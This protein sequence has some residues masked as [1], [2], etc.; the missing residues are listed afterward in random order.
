MTQQ[1]SHAEQV[2]KLNEMI[3]DIN[4]AMLTTEE[5]DG[6]LRSRPMGTQQVDFDGDLWFFTRID[7]AKVD[8]VRRERHVNVSYADDDSQRYVS[9]SGTA[10]V[11]RDQK[12]INELWNPMAKIWFPDG[13]EDPSLALLKV[14]VTQAEYWDAASNRMVQLAKLAKGLITGDGAEELG[15][16]QK[17][18]L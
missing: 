2:E 5:A 18:A 8:E 6:T 13:K 17:L 4:I 14:H 9:V 11:M 15:D 3:R 16:N 7:A 12:K 10:K 1:T